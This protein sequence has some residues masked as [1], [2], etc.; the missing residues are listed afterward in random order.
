MALG[1]NIPLLPIPT[2]DALAQAVPYSQRLLCPILDARKKQL[3]A[4]LYCWKA[5]AWDKLTPDLLLTPAELA[6]KIDQP[7]MFLA[8][9]ASE[10]GEFLQHTLGERAR[11]APQNF[12]FPRAQQVAE[13]G[14]VELKAGRT[15]SAQELV[16]HYVRRPDARGQ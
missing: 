7:V 6:A 4:A 8:D 15:V 3:Y 5:K 10:Y 9:A 14:L 2:L 13:L 12:C 11:F 1:L 16:P